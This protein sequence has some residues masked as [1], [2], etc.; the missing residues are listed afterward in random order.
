MEVVASLSHGRTAAA[1]CGLFTYKSVPVIFEPPCIL[2]V[3][4]VNS[5]ISFY[6]DLCDPCCWVF[7]CR[8]RVDVDIVLNISLEE[9]IH[10][11][12]YSELCVHSIGSTTENLIG[13]NLE[14]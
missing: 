12:E 3:L 7:R 2:P 8:Q 5:V 6:I 9:S 14:Q 10:S 4:L 13:E 1:Q 11:S